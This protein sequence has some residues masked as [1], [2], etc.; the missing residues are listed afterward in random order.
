MQPT[1]HIQVLLLSIDQGM[2]RLSAGQLVHR[3]QAG[4]VHTW[5]PPTLVHLGDDGAASALQLLQLVLKLVLL[6]QLVLV[7]P[8]DGALYLLL[9]LLLVSRIKLASHLKPTGT[10]RWDVPM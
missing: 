5:P 10:L 4:V 7:Q 2:R 1:P 6:C 9:N 8:A 3:W